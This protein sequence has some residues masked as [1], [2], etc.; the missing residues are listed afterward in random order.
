MWSDEAESAEIETVISEPFDGLW[1]RV[2]GTSEEAPALSLGAR[3]KAT[4]EG[5]YRPR[6]FLQRLP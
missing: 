1:G 6:L 2:S 3:R 5:R 4:A